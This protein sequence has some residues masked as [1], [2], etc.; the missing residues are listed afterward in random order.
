MPMT[1]PMPSLQVVAQNVTDAKDVPALTALCDEFR[2]VAGQ[3]T[4]AGH[5]QATT[6]ASA[7]ARTVEQIIFCEMKD[8]EAAL[9][10]V[11][12]TVDELCALMQG[13]GAPSTGD[14]GAGMPEAPQVDV[15]AHVDEDAPS[16]G[17]SEH[18]LVE[19]PIKEDDR[20]LIVEF[21]A[22]ATGHIESAEVELL[23]LEDNPEDL[24]AINGIFR[25]FH[26]I[27]GVAGFVN[28]K[29]IGALAH[30]SESL[31]DLARS[32]KLPMTRSAVD[33][34][35]AA[36]DCLKVLFANVKTAEQTNTIAPPVRELPALLK[37]VNDYATGANRPSDTSTMMHAVTPTGDSSPAPAGAA[38]PAGASSSDAS[39][40]ISTERL[41]ALINTV[42]ELVISQA[43]VSQDITSMPGVSTRAVRN[44]SQLEKITRELQGISMSM[45]MV[46]LTGVFRKM[47]RLVRDLATRLGKEIDFVQT[48]ADT[49]LDRTLTESI[50]DPLVHM[51]RNAVDHGLETPEQRRQVGKPE[52][53]RVELKAFHQGGSIVIQIT[54][55]GKGLN[56]KRILQKAIDAGIV[57]PGSD[58]SDEQI[59]QLIFH[60]GLSTAEKVTAVSGRGVGMDVVRK[61]IEALRG[62]VEISSVEG[63]G[64]TFTIRLPLTLAIIEG[65][66]VRVGE[67]KFIIPLGNIDQSLRPSAEQ[68]NKVIGKGEMCSVRDELI[69]IFRLHKL[70]NIHSAVKD[71]TDALLVVVRDNRSACALMVDELVGHKQ[72]VIKSL[73]P[74]IGCVRGVSGGAILGD[75][76]ISLILDVPGL[77]DL[78]MNRI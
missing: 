28:L 66:V 14:T 50:G 67:D 72:V 44:L 7:A 54:D 27:K 11:R 61:N 3:L 78:A 43:M 59:F 33:V 63:K 34:V 45:R 47:A 48:G 32:G 46:P 31:L 9:A 57:Q 25:A 1:E 52:T 53:G 35:L 21:I 26:T 19:Q 55:D 69:P 68:I 15:A 75:G 56:K 49:E 76:N 62:R 6:R 60:A 40:K 16:A 65:L 39:V 29:Q 70:F 13:V 23:K 24:E 64:S 37:R 5:A 4:R 41:D 10:D 12:K 58:L 18:D 8:T 30:V 22:E 20:G 17:G 38:P 73:G 77:L 2:N 51:V 74:S 42:G 36:L 71:P